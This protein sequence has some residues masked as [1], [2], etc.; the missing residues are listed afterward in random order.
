MNTDSSNTGVV[1]CFCTLSLPYNQ[2]V[3]LNVFQ[4]S[5]SEETQ[6]FFSHKKCLNDRIHPSIPRHPDLA[7]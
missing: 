6:S 2:A 1:C 5:D 7:E 4:V 3:V